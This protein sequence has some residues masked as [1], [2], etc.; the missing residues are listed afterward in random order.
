MARI[1]AED[2]LKVIPNRFDMTLAAAKRARQL[3]TTMHEP[4]VEAASDK[5]TVVALREIA[6]G[7]VDFS[8]KLMGTPNISETAEALQN[9]DAQNSE[10]EVEV[11]EQES[12]D[13]TDNEALFADA[14]ITDEAAQEQPSSDESDNG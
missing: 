6:A 5:V 9:I 4:R 1:T 10:A 8:D 3:A 14:A 2:C 7:H 11:S 12:S 13:Q